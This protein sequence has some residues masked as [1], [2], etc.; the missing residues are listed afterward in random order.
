L[1]NQLRASQDRVN[2]DKQ[3]KVY[4]QS[5]NAAPP[6]VDLDATNSRSTSPYEATIRREEAHLAELQARY[7]PQYP[8]IRKVRNTIAELKA[9]AAQEAKDQPALQQEDS[10]DLAHRALHNNPV[11]QAQ[12]TKLDEEIQ[13][14]TKRQAQLEPQIAT[15]MA[16]LEHQ[17][18][19]E[20]QISGLMRDYDRL[21]EHYNRLLDKKLSAQ[22]A[23]AL[24]TR[25]Q[26]ERF[27][28]LDSAP[29]PQQPMGPN[30][31]L[32]SLASLIGGLLGGLGLAM[33]V[34]MTDET[35]RSEREAAQILGKAVLAGVPLILAPDE[36]FRRRLRAVGAVAG[37]AFAAG[38][39][40]L[41]LPLIF[42]VTA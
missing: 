15:H 34:E 17:P 31:P 32:F 27:L 13:E 40:G 5:T 26:G 12:V 41:L 38:L 9:K 3:E 28:I 25:Q 24:E 2:Q 11:V 7:G 33:V 42:T 4:L 6:T 14:E 16:K 8:D 29:V 1:Q 22:M 18:I 36:R 35:V 39:I 20:Q 37:T 19:F 10:A 23:L 30:R 21:R